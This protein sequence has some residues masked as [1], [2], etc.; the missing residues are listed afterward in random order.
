MNRALATCAAALAIATG[1]CSAQDQPPADAP[2]PGD[3]Q[4]WIERQLAGARAALNAPAT[5]GAKRGVFMLQ[6]AAGS[7]GLDCPELR[8]EPLVGQDSPVQLVILVH[9]L[10]EP[11]NLWDTLG[12]ALAR[13]GHFVAKFDYPNDQAIADSAA[14]LLEALRDLH[15]RGARH[16]VLIGHSMGGLVA[17]DALTRADGYCGAV[18]GRYDL[19]AVDRL[20]T[21]A[22]P[23]HGS[24]LARFR[25]FLELRERLGRVLEPENPDWLDLFRNDDGNGEAGRD[26]T[27]GSEFLTELN[28]RTM[29]ADLPATVILC[30]WATPEG[31]ALAGLA[32]SGPVR[33]VLGNG[34]S[35]AMLEALGRVSDLIGDGVVTKDSACATDAEECIVV[36]ADH[37]SALQPR[38]IIDV[39]RPMF[40]CDDD[41]TFEPPGIEVILRRLRKN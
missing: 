26:L 3:A 29:P 15:T 34:S 19:P 14:G 39:I 6:S 30:R 41:P 17:R 9:G 11:G 33:S 21:V 36:D 28:A 23:M 25:S 40:L 1:S 12:P 24:Q 13:D 2:P 4:N 5:H 10:D 8:W 16:V 35:E 32:A 18:R 22:T 7:E 27:P 20:I 37:R 31:S 38:R